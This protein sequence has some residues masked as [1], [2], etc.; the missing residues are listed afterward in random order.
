MGSQA[1]IETRH[2]KPA[3]THTAFGF[4]FVEAE[5]GVGVHHTKDEQAKD[6]G[7]HDNH[8]AC[9]QPPILVGPEEY[10]WNVDQPEEKEC[11]ELGCCEANRF[12]NVIGDAGESTAEHCVKHVHHERRSSVDCQIASV[13]EH[14]RIDI[15]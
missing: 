7:Y 2:D 3:R 11:K 15:D 1:R 14:A 4:E 9:E 12:R 6:C 10:E 5:V 13:G 8:F